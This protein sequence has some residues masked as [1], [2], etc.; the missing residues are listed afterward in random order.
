[1]EVGTSRLD[2]FF[3]GAATLDAGAA[4]DACTS[5]ARIS[6]PGPDPCRLETST[7][8]SFARRRA[9]GEILAPGATACSGAVAAACAGSFVLCDTARAPGAEK[10]S[11]AGGFSPGATIHA[12]VCPTGI[13]APGE[14][15]IPTRIP[16]AGASN[17][18]TALSVSISSSGSP[19][20]TRSPSCLRQAMSLPVSCA[21]S[22]AGITTLKAIIIC[23]RTARLSVRSSYALGLGAGFDHLDHAFAGRSFRFADGRQRAVDSEIVRAG[24]QKFFRRETRDHFVSGWRNYNFF[25][26]ARRAPSVGRRPERFQRKHHAGLDFYRVL[27]RNQTA[28]HGLLPDSESDAVAILQREAG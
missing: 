16:S 24:H 2:A 1:M 12:I 26:D 19:L 14:A 9:L 3:A 13:S 18:T 20:V 15:V 28:D 8:N 17:S 23:G 6:P 21:I 11:S 22:S 4:A 7:P 5:E 25:F 27:E 10:D